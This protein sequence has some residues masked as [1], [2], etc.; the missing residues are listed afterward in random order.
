MHEISHLGSIIY[1]TTK[2][3]IRAYNFTYM[4]TPNSRK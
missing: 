3:K 4:Y 2:K 1:R